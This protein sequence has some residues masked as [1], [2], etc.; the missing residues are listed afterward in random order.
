M[1]CFCVSTPWLLH[2]GKD[3]LK[4]GNDSVFQG[5]QFSPFSCEIILSLKTSTE[6]NYKETMQKNREL[7]LWS[8]QLNKLSDLKIHLVDEF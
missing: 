1:G 8:T 3:N 2:P 4:A 5:S 7:N 6:Q